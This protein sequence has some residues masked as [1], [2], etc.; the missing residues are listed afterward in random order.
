ME[1]FVEKERACQR[2]FESRGP[3]WHL[4]TS[5]KETPMMFR[6]ASDFEFVMNVI[7]QTAY[8]LSELCI[9]A[10]TIMDNHIHI[11]A[12]G[13][14]SVLADGFGYIRRRLSR[15]CSLRNRV[16]L[17]SGFRAQYKM[18]DSLQ[19]LRATIAYVHRNGYV[20]HSA[21]TPFSYPWGT[22]PYY[23]GFPVVPQKTF[24]ELSKLDKRKIFRGRAPALPADWQIVDGHICPQAYCAIEAGRSMFRDARQYFAML[25]KNVESYAEL[26]AE[27]DDR[28]YLTDAEIFSQM[29]WY[30]KKLYGVA[31]LKE[32][33]RAQTFDI[34]RKMHN[35]CRS[36]NGQIRRVL[37]LTQYEVDTL[38][39]S[40]QK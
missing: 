13:S 22:G 24:G 27:L 31:S 21:Y 1:K 30:V 9:L 26:A 20:A 25:T 17:P 37:N 33:S 40:L 29:T 32:L 18:I 16:P 19:A 5:G 12:A 34:A 7:A 6:E 23:F 11:V 2:A 39:P 10:F 3:F 15:D 8:G 4:F 28:D 38:F 35:E 36:S 14:E